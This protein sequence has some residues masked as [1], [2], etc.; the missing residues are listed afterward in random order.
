MIKLY[1]KINCGLAPPVCQLPVRVYWVLRMYN[2]S[3]KK[4]SFK[5]SISLSHSLGFERIGCQQLG[6]KTIKNY[7]SICFKL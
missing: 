6:L 3:G 4:I 7:H 2:K 5:T 1:S